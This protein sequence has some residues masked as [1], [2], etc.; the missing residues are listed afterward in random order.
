MFETFGKPELPDYLKRRLI[1]TI[2][3][4]AYLTGD[5]K[6]ALAAAPKVVEAKPAI[7]PFMTAY[8][9]AK[10]PAERSTAGLFLLLKNGEMS[11]YLQAGFDAESEPQFDMWQDE[12]WWCEQYDYTYDDSGNEI[13]KGAFTPP[14]LTRQLSDQARLQKSALKKIN[15]GLSYLS[16]RV[17]KWAQTGVPDKRLPESL[18]IIF[19]ANQ[20]VK[21]SCGNTSEETRKSAGDILKTRYPRSKWTAQMF[22][23][24]KESENQ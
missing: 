16:S 4:R 13:P 6:T 14:F 5:E 17:L 12:R 9:N 2:W 10:T 18:Y 21:Y 23:D 24:L 20:W 7:E 15:D 1:F 8:V 19:Q 11:P 3:T 22:A